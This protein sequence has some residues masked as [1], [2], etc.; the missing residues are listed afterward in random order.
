MQAL[1]LVKMMHKNHPQYKVV[2]GSTFKTNEV[3]FK[4]TE[5]HA[6]SKE[7][8][9]V[10][11][12]IRNFSEIGLG[13][14]PKAFRRLIC[15]L[16]SDVPSDDEGFCNLIIET[17]LMLTNFRVRLAHEGQLLVM[18][19]EYMEGLHPQSESSESETSS[20]GDSDDDVFRRL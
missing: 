18:N 9:K 6:D 2:G 20:E 7:H 3:C 14:I 17:T 13:P 1:N 16:P 8:L 10:L 11:R 5:S 4:V 12:R 15:K 19:R